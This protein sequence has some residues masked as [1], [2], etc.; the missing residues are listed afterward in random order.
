MLQEL[1]FG[2]AVFLVAF[3][4]VRS[5]FVLWIKMKH[6]DFDFGLAPNFL[7][8]LKALSLIFGC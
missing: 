4:L 6:F 1:N 5:Y 7:C 2:V 3:T 8:T